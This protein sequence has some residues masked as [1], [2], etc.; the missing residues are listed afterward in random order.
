MKIKNL[1]PKDVLN[2]RIRIPNYQK[3]LLMIQSLIRINLNIL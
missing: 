1:E 3:I 2:S